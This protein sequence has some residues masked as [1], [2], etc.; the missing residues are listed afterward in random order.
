MKHVV[1]N[2]SWKCQLHCPYCWLPHVKINRKAPERT[3][4]EWGAAL[5]DACSPGDVI[6]FSGGDPLLYDGIELLLYYLGAS[7]IRWA[8]TT[9]ALATEYIERLMKCHLMGC[10]CINVSDH[11]GNEAAR[12]NIDRLRT[13]FPVHTHRVDHPSAGHHEQGAKIIPYQ[14][15]AEGQATD[16]KL[17]Y[18]NAG[19]RHWVTDTEGNLYR[20]VVDMQVGNESFGNVFSNVNEPEPFICNF[21]CTS[22][23]TSEPEAWLLDMREAV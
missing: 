17:R 12:A 20:C 8:I 15:W 10:I 5:L 18:C 7:G 13:K 23:Y 3:W 1:V 11:T 4:T 9:N 6:D 16:G 19:I 22:C 14:K 2:L 21:G